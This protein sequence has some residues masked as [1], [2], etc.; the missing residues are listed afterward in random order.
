MTGLPP[1]ATAAVAASAQRW[2]RFSLSGQDYAVDIRSVREVLSQADIEPIPG[3]PAVV[4]GVIN[5][6]GQIVTVL[7]F[8]RWLGRAPNAAPR[9]LLVM[10]HLGIVLAL[11]IDVIHDVTRLDPDEIKP[12]PRTGNNERPVPLAG[13]V[14]REAGLLTLLNADVLLPQLAQG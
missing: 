1:N 2:I 7:D 3:A 8:G 13:L 12:V 11:A 14:V 6:R 5:L 4:L 9:P 10:D